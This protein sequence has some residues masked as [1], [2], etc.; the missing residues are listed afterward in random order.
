[1]RPSQYNVESTRTIEQLEELTNEESKWLQVA[2]EECCHSRMASDKT[3]THLPHRQIA[4]RLG[5][6]RAEWK[7]KFIQL[8][9]KFKG[10]DAYLCWVQDTERTAFKTKR[11]ATKRVGRKP[12]VVS[13]A[14][15]LPQ[16]QNLL[17]K[18]Q[19]WVLSVLCSGLQMEDVLY[20]LGMRPDQLGL[21]LKN[22]EKR[23]PGFLGRI[24]ELGLLEG[25]AEIWSRP[26]SSL[27][28]RNYSDEPNGP[29]FEEPGNYE[30]S[31]TS[32]GE[33]AKFEL[34]DGS[35]DRAVRK[36]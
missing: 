9:K 28:F 36:F 24:E 34:R 5:M 32:D 8:S 21:I 29:S 2:V 26:F 16:L 23:V 11:E 4:E 27:P 15:Q 10:L 1:M 19:Q 7:P 12:K 25:G 13:E 18:K 14:F 3:L 6:T 33:G 30:K 35:T 20:E 31:I 17:T 22:I